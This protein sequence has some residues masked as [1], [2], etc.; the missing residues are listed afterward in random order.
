[1]FQK[2]YQ[3]KESLRI[4][5]PWY[6]V[7]ERIG[8]V[9]PLPCN[10]ETTALALAKNQRIDASYTALLQYFKALPSKRMKRMADLRPSQIR[11]AV[12]CSLR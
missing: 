9:R 11:T 3:F 1:M 4:E 12:R 5:P 8:P 10:A 6:D 7:E 2:S